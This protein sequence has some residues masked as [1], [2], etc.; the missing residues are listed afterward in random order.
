MLEFVETEG[1]IDHV[2]PVQ[3][4]IRL[5]VPPGSK[6]LE[7]AAIRPS[8]GSV[9]QASFFHPWTH[10]DSRMD[11]LHEEVCATVEEAARASED[12]WITFHRVRALAYATR[13]SRVTAGVLL[14]L[15]K[16]RHRPPRLTEPWF[17]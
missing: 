8:L 10:P 17:C 13:D 14:E 16:D 11:R 3:Y 15:P 6:L 9:D 2:D 5:L 1:L 7:R 4:S 12:P